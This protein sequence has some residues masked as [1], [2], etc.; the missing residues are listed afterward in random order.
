M[1]ERN[2][3]MIEMV[4]EGFTYKQIGR[5]YGVSKQRVHQIVSQGDVRYFHPITKER[6]IFNGIR[7]WM[8]ANKV[9]VASITRKIYGNT[10]PTCHQKLRSYLV[11]KNEMRMS[12]IEKLLEI[13]GLTFE[14]AF[15]EK[16]NERI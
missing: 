11:G 15:K 2:Q 14:Q 8:N 4:R 13:T 3:Q 16:D 5:V 12:T 1:H 6:C 7:N 9:D 10:S